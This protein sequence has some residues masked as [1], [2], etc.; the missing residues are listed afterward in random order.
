MFRSD[1]RTVYS[2]ANNTLQTAIHDRMERQS[3]TTHSPALGPAGNW[4]PAGRQCYRSRN[5]VTH[6]YAPALIRQS[7]L[8]VAFGLAECPDFL[9]SAVSVRL[10]MLQRVNCGL[11]YF[12]SWN[13]TFSCVYHPHFF[14][15]VL[16]LYTRT[17]HRKQE[18]TN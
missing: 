5:R 12:V 16:S 7:V 1:P 11:C 15:D 13:A 9:F 4:K 10:E 18:R 3:I 2:A 17:K 14:H 8:G 6:A